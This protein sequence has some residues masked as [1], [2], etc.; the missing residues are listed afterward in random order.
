MSFG[1]YTSGNWGRWVDSERHFRS[2]ISLADVSQVYTK[3]VKNIPVNDSRRQILYGEIGAA[4]VFFRRIIFGLY[5][6][7]VFAN[8]HKTCEI[9]TFR[10]HIFFQTIANS[11]HYEIKRKHVS[12]NGKHSP[13]SSCLQELWNTMWVK[14]LKVYISFQEIT[15]P[16]TVKCLQPPTWKSTI[17]RNF[18]TIR[19]IDK[20]PHQLPGSN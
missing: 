2:V 3:I 8:I 1:L 13:V 19:Y 11:F 12:N 20:F 4:E 15:M 17:G 5:V 6:V 9:S 16:G 10:R 7:D 14:L 18:Q